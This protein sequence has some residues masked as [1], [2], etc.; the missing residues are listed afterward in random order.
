MVKSLDFYGVKALYYAPWSTVLTLEKGP[1]MYA[2]VVIPFALA[3]FW[4]VVVVLRLV[5]LV[6][7]QRA[8]T[9]A[10]W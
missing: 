1:F 8:L 3:A 5:P 4:L 9:A 6:R 2:L 7:R 10:G